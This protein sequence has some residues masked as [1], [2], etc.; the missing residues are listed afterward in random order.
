RFHQGRAGLPETAEKQQDRAIKGGRSL[1]FFLL[2]SY[3]FRLLP[4]A[5][6]PLSHKAFLKIFN[7]P[8]PVRTASPSPAGESFP[9]NHK[10]K[11]SFSCVGK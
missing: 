6:F 5:A 8:P 9:N 11:R 2:L 7:F 10:L 1:D 4:K 3:F